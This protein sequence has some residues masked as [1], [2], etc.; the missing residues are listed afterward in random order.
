MWD[1]YDGPL[2]LDAMAGS[3][4][5]SRFYFSRLFRSTTGTSP[6]RFLTAIR[7]YQAKVLLRETGMSVT[8]IAYGVGYNSLGTFTGRFT[9]SVGVSPARYRALAEGGPSLPSGADDER[10]QPGAVIHGRIHLPLLDECVRVYIGAFPGPAIEGRPR[11]CDVVESEGAYELVGVP[12]GEWFVRAVAFSL[13]SHSAAQR[14]LAVGA[15]DKVEAHQGET[16]SVDLPLRVTG[17]FDLPILAAL[18]ELESAAMTCVG[19]PPRA[20][21]AA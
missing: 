16:I 20:G 9:R 12:P 21:L 18:P 6:G 19:R 1:G 10:L 15:C 11:V 2:S 7:L 3:A 8:D 5:L 13:D 14:P 17:V 4:H